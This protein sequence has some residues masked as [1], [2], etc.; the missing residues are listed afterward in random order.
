M[1]KPVY[2]TKQYD[3]VSATMHS[4][5][6]QQETQHRRTVTYVWLLYEQWVMER[7]PTLAELHARLLG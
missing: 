3:Y 6:E 7:V 2:D 1:F 5:V 4:V